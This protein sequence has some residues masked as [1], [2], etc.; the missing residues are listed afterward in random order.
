MSV[1]PASPR[2]IWAS[3]PAEPASFVAR[4]TR[5]SARITSR[6]SL[7]TSVCS[8]LDLVRGCARAARMVCVTLQRYCVLPTMVDSAALVRWRCT[9]ALTHSA[10]VRAQPLRLP[11]CTRPSLPSA[12]RTESTLTVQTLTVRPSLPVGTAWTAP[13]SRAACLASATL[14]PLVPAYS[15]RV[16]TSPWLPPCIT[17][18]GLPRAVARVLP[19]VRFTRQ[20]TR[21]HCF[22]TCARLTS[23][24][25]NA[26]PFR[27]LTT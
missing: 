5:C 24:W 26:R 17:R 19:S 7:A 11:R 14:T 13:S 18:V 4:P 15:R 25:P 23:M 3:A 21:T 27:V 22:L 12:A 16:R 20:R 9:R 6:A 8:T 1:T 10:T 2:A